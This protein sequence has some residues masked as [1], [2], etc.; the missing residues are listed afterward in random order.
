[1]SPGFKVFVSYAHVNNASKWVSQ[2]AHHLRARIPGEMQIPAGV[3]VWLDEIH[4]SA[5]EPFPADIR[6]AVCSSDIYVAVFSHGYCNS[7]W[8]KREREAFLAR[9]KE[10][11]TGR[12]F[13]IHHSPVDRDI[14]HYPVEFKEVLGV[15]FYQQEDDK[16][17]NSFA[18]TLGED[19]K[20]PDRAYFVQ[21]RK[22]A[23]AIGKKLDQLSRSQRPEGQT[24]K[25]SVLSG[26]PSQTG[27]VNLLVVAPK[28]M[29]SEAHVLR[30][31]IHD[32]RRLRIEGHDIA[33]M[34]ETA[35]DVLAVYQHFEPSGRSGLDVMALV[36][37]S[38][39]GQ[40]SD[41]SGRE[42]ASL[43]EGAYRAALEKGAAV[44]LYRCQRELTFQPDDPDW[45]T[46]VMNV[47]SVN[48]FFAL[49]NDGVP[50]NNRVSRFRTTEELLS[51]FESD[52]KEH[53]SGAVDRSLRVVKAA[54]TT[55]QA[56]TDTGVNDLLREYLKWV[57]QKHERLELRGIG[58]T[59]SLTTIPLE[60]VYVALRGVRAS[61]N[62]RQQSRKLFQAE[63]FTLIRTLP[64]AISADEFARLVDEA[65]AQALIENPLM[66][67]LVERDRPVGESKPEAEVV[68]S[69]GEAFRTERW[70][71]LL[72]DPG[73]GKTTL[74]R[75][76]ALKLAQALLA[77]PPRRVESLACQVD[78]S[79]SR[80]DSRKVDLGPARLPILVRVSEYSEALLRARRQGELLPLAAFLG[81]HTWLGEAFEGGGERLKLLIKAFLEQGRAVVLLDGMDE[82]TASSQRDDVVHAIES[83]ITK[84]G[85]AGQATG[86]PFET[87]GNQVLIT[88]RIAG[89]HA[90][91]IIGPVAHM[92]VQPMERRAVEHFCDA[93]CLAVN[94][95]DLPENEDL[96]VQKAKA[97]AAGLKAEIFNPQSP[98][99]WELAANPLMITILALIYRKTKGRLPRQRSELY[100]TALEILIENWRFA[101]ITT[102]EFIYVLSPLAAKI[103]SEHA[104]GLIR[105]NVMREVITAELARYRGE[106]ADDPPPQFVREV[107]SFLRRVREDVG[108]L[109]ER[110]PNLF[111]FLHLTFQEYLAALYL[112][113]D[114]GTAG[115]AIVDVLDDPRWRE[116]ILLALGHVSSNPDWGPGARARLLRQILDADDPLGELLP[117]GPL[118]VIQAL[119]EMDN[120]EDELVGELLDRLLRAYTASANDEVSGALARQIERA[121]NAMYNSAHQS[122]L[123]AGLARMMDSAAG[124]RSRALACASLI[125]A[126]GWRHPKFV[127][128]L[129]RCQIYDEA[130]WSLP[131]TNVL[132]DWISREVPTGDLARSEREVK[133]LRS[134]LD[135]VLGGSLDQSLR[136]EIQQLQQEL[137]VIGET[138]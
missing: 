121:I 44:F 50:A 52:L 24:T 129:L 76:I 23:W 125:Q 86:A 35:E 48:H 95:Q 84:A 28:D 26:A 78:P 8:C 72:G 64:Q 126:N 132:R 112:V 71:V 10:D 39:L 88:S 43:V 20:R 56:R 101:D 106:S 97:E 53:V 57:V 105:E 130:R 31:R 134:E 102:E 109:A 62:E 63:L 17:D 18:V 120:V 108:L 46:K 61:N 138:T 123:V 100:H 124:A 99:V 15:R 29:G 69:L 128:P 85:Q 70:L 117:R 21:V 37:W 113:R 92:T 103:H 60:E 74:L 80:S 110:S 54:V 51:Q 41:G 137:G 22:V 104:T 7:E 5:N 42:R 36:V 96:A 6:D 2:F 12:L 131:V 79:V 87:G 77:I 13:V 25:V 11:V 1:M 118:L 75:W 27:R 38:D 83:F 33:I 45:E 94:H 40:G 4:L 30:N 114:R 116:P 81:S 98:Q 67:L 107:K 47:K 119:P 133:E 59:D 32:L 122:Q 49:F 91:P 89:Y 111:G 135:A 14:P 65:E 9:W 82:L 93:W 19:Q 66:P 34:L 127:G 136:T 55:V 68:M 58:G 3:Q 115:Q 73:S 90:S 16:V